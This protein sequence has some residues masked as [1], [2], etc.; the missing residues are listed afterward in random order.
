MEVLQKYDTAPY[1]I[2]D[3]GF[4]DMSN[5]ELEEYCTIGIELDRR[6]GRVNSSKMKNPVY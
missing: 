1:L 5:V 3:R 4:G 2:L 6:Q